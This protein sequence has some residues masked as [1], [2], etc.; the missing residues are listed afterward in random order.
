MFTD[1]TC[2]TSYVAGDYLF[3]REDIHVTCGLEFGGGWQPDVICEASGHRLNATTTTYS[4]KK[5]TAGLRVLAVKEFDGSVINCGV[6]FSAS[7]KPVWPLQVANNIP[8][9]KLQWTSDVLRLT[10]M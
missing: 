8:V 5:V 10:C 7:K 4:N 3:E 6:Q 9:Y 1:F 2:S